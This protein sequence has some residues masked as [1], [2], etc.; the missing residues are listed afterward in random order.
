MSFQLYFSKLNFSSKC[1]DYLILRKHIVLME[2]NQMQIQKL[3]AIDS[4]K[5]PIKYSLN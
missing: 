2:E 3:Q 4:W 5:A 1:H